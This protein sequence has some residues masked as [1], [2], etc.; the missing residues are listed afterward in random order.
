MSDEFHIIDT[1]S[2]EQAI[3]D[4]VLHDVSEI[5]KDAGFKCPV[6]MTNRLHSDMT[7]SDDVKKKFGCD[8]VGRVWDTV[9]MASLAVRRSPNS[10]RLIKFK[11]LLPTTDYGRPFSPRH[12]VNLWM[13]LE[14]EAITIMYPDEY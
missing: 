10:H 2:R 7:P 8:Y 4:S 12:L 5:A 3:A 9:W 1:Y 6:Y 13:V 14:N 11:V